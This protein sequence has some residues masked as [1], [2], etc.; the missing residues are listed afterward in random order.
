MLK[1]WS[2]RRTRAQ[3][4]IRSG[5]SKSSTK[6]A[7]MTLR[8]GRRQPR[9]FSARPTSAKSRCV[10]QSARTAL[11]FHC[12]VLT[13]GSHLQTLGRPPS[14]KLL[15]FKPRK[16]Y[17][18]FEETVKHSYFIYPDEE[19]SCERSPSFPRFLSRSSEL[20]SATS[21]QIALHWLDSH[22]C[23][24]A[25]V[26]A[27]EGSGRLCLVPRSIELAPAGRAAPPAGSSDQLST[28]RCGSWFGTEDTLDGTLCRK[29]SCIRMGWWRFREAFTS[30]SCRSWTTCETTT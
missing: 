7:K 21:A 1:N 30:A 28:V 8:R 23:C 29:R 14:L 15:G 10:L 13:W 3:R 26:D 27:Q 16:G 25:Q 4:S 9:S 22:V 17:L 6:S 2:D 12:G 20:T 5:T 18:R 24:A 11:R 19:V